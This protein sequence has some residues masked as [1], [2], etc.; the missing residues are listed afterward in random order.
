MVNERPMA[1]EPSPFPPIGFDRCFQRSIQKPN[2]IFFDNAAGAQIPQVVFNAVHHHLLHRNVQRGGRYKK[3]VEVDDNHSARA[4]ECRRLINARHRKEIAFGMNATCFC[5]YLASLWPLSQARNEI[6]VTDSTTKRISPPGCNWRAK[7]NRSLW[8]KM[9]EDNNLDVEDLAPLLAGET[10]GLPALWPRTRSAP[11][12]MSPRSPGLRTPQA[13]R[14]FSTA[15]TTRRTQL[16][17]FRHSIATILSAPAI[18]S[19]GRAWALC[20]GVWSCCMNCQPFA[21]LSFRMLLHPRLRQAPSFTRMS[22]VWQ[23][24]VGYLEELGAW[25]DRRKGRL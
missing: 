15:S 1:P 7:D 22:P 14:S 13:Q 18:R 11:W 25:D 10:A 19:S 5:T 2:F 8:W 6:V 9:R 16:S 17:T 3:S 12:S 4:G 23:A 21:R 24:A 20:G